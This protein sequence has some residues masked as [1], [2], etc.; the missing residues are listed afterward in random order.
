MICTVADKRL[1]TK[2]IASFCFLTTSNAAKED[3]R[4]LFD[5]S[6]GRE[7]YLYRTHMVIVLD[8]SNPLKRTLTQ[9]FELR[10]SDRRSC[11]PLK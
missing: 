9:Y 11:S 7:E 8:T 10:K 6:R 1:I 3:T 5:G 4:E 2:E